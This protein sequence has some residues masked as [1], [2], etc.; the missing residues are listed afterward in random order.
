MPEYRFTIAEDDA[1]TVFFVRRMI[2]NAFPGSSISTFSNAEDALKHI[3]E[4]N[5]DML[6]TDHGMGSMSGTE[7]IR[8]LRDRGFQIPIIMIS[9]SPEAEKEAQVAGATKFLLKKG[10]TAELEQILRKLLPK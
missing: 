1:I 10:T 2:S 5:T 4:T 8:Q 3:L 6:I 9:G 7:L